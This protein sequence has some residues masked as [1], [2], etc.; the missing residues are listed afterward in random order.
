M[1]LNMEE[2]NLIL[3]AFSK[4]CFPNALDQF[5]SACEQ[6][7]MKINTK[8]ELLCLSRKPVYAANKQ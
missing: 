3:L 8:N 6:V 4:Q 7:G 2:D 1:E 5:S